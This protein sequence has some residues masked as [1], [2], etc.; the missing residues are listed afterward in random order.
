MPPACG[1]SVPGRLV[2]KR[3]ELFPEQPAWL[4]LVKPRWYRYIRAA[5]ADAALRQALELSDSLTVALYS[6]DLKALFR[7]ATKT[8]GSELYRA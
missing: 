7:K 6:S 5:R 2:R 4:L 3:V 1:W 8:A